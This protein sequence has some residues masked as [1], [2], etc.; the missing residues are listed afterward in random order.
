[1]IV[2]RDGETSKLS[3]FDSVIAIGVFDGLH[4]G[5]QA[6]INMLLRLDGERARDAVATIV[7]FDPHP[8]LLLAPERE[9]RLLGTLEQRLEGFEALG[10][11]QVRVVTFDAALASESASNFVGRV[12]AGEL[13][14]WEIVVGED[15]RFGHDRKGDVALLSAEGQRY[16]FGVYEAPTFGEPRWSSTAVREALEIGDLDSANATLGR[17]FVLRGRVVHG[18]ARGAELGFATANLATAALQL[19]P[20]EGI[21]AGAARTP[22]RTWR[23]AAIS[24]GT[25]P[26]FYD[27][28]PVLVE[29]HLPGYEGDLYDTTLDVAFLARLRGEAVFTDVAALIDQIGRD[30]EQTLAIFEKFSPFGSALLE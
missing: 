17:P 13:H 9:L 25:R 5:H 22:E 23:P 2:V 30:V 29:V 12:L 18:D 11:E 28:G 16:G 26:Q 24:I 8:A 4:L 10:I 1:M 6:V 7:T 15:F 20:L 19:V 3:D 14:A 21:Y 27:H